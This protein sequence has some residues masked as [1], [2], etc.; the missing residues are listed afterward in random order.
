M[1]YYEQ[2]VQRYKAT[3]SIE[4]AA[5]ASYKTDTLT[6]VATKNRILTDSGAPSRMMDAILYDANYHGITKE[7]AQFREDQVRTSMLNQYQKLGLNPG[8]ASPM[9]ASV[10]AAL[11][12]TIALF[13]SGREAASVVVPSTHKPV[14]KPNIDPALLSDRPKGPKAPPL[15]TPYSGATGKQQEQ[16]VTRRDQATR[17]MIEN[18]PLRYSRQF[19]EDG[20]EVGVGKP[21]PFERREHRLHELLKLAKIKKV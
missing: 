15:Y 6:D 12:N 9:A 16:A 8:D 3:K 18:D 11:N 21:A 4:Q 17:E 5:L 13:Q 10:M 20:S 1:N 14:S 2:I 19:P 7:K